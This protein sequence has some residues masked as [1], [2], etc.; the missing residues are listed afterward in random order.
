[1][2]LGL[3][4]EQGGLPSSLEAAAADVAA[5][6]SFTGHEMTGRLRVVLWRFDAS[7]PQAELVALRP[8]PFHISNCVL[9]SEMGVHFSPCGRMLAVCVACRVRSLRQTPSTDNF[10]ALELR[11]IDQKDQ[12][13][14][15]QSPSLSLGCLCSVHGFNGLL[16]RVQAFCVCTCILR[17]PTCVNVDAWCVSVGPPGM[18]EFTLW[19]LLAFIQTDHD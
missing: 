18:C 3:G 2:A 11:R 8:R 19:F 16:R 17:L 10:L 14:C 15:C 7:Q 1:M 13:V 12:G 6:H 5:S 9:C 4:N